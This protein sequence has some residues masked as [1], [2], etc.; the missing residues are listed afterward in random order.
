MD[1]YSQ[2]SEFGKVLIFL[3]LGTLFV[4]ATIFLNKIV[5]VK[6]P[7]PIKNS[8][9]ECGEEVTGSSWIQF[10]SRFYVIALVFLLFDVEMI[11]VFPWATVFS[12]QELISIDNRWG[13]LAFIEMLIFIGILLIGLVYVWRKKD[14]RWIR[15]SV[16]TPT[17]ATAIPLDAY[18]AI[19]NSIYTPGKKETSDITNDIIKTNNTTDKPKFV[20]RFKKTSP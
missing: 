3:V 20:P 6:R 18:S 1:E 13:W 12:N 17:V 9:Y 11:F 14:L 7:N 4:C 10:N 2:I 19:N 15:P 8:S 16:P 5:S